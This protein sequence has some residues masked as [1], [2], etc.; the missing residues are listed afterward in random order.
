[1]LKFSSLP[2]VGAHLKLQKH[3]DSKVD[4]P[5]LS[6]L[7]P[8]EEIDQFNITLNSNLTNHQTALNVLVNNDIVNSNS[9]K[10]SRGYSLTDF[11]S[12]N[13]NSNTS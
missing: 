8:D 13:V 10:D 3:V 1:M 2:A 7:D 9:P 11:D 4:E 12:V 6:G 5:K